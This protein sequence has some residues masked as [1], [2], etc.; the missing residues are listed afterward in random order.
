MAW[1]ETTAVCRGLTLEQVGNMRESKYR[2]VRKTGSVHM[3]LVSRP[4]PIPLSGRL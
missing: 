4:A 3:Q 1:R 2:G